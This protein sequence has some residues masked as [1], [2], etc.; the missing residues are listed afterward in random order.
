MVIPTT[1]EVR[2]NP[3]LTKEYAMEVIRHTLLG[4]YE[5]VP[6]DTVLSSRYIFVKHSKWIGV[7]VKLEQKIDKT[8]FHLDWVIP[9]ILRRWLLFIIALITEVNISAINKSP[10]IMNEVIKVIKE[11]PEFN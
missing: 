6:A 8:L 1:I 5:V 10:T 9:G 4:K 11:S 3:Q 2:H 7:R